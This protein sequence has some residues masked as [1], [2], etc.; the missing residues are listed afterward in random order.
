MVKKKIS[1]ISVLISLIIVSQT[2]TTY[3]Y[4]SKSIDTSNLEYK[5]FNPSFE[6]YQYI[7]TDRNLGYRYYE[8]N[9]HIYQLMDCENW[10]SAK[11]I[12]EDNGGYLASIT[13]QEENDFI[14]NLIVN[15]N[16]YI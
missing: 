7:E 8:F 3:A 15:D 14:F 11:D 13:S 4:E 5:R 2:V 16:V 6:S 10:F 1:L 9:N 12:A